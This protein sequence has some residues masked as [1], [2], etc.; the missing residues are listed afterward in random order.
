MLVKTAF[1]AAPDDVIDIHVAIK[2]EGPRRIEIWGVGSRVART[3][4][5]R[6]HGNV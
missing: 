2:G 3:I 1:I 4:N 5:L 6:A